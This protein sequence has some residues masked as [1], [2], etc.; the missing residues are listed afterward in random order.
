MNTPLLIPHAQPC[1]ELS[2]AQALSPVGAGK[3]ISQQSSCP[4]YLLLVERMKK[5]RLVTFSSSL[6][7]LFVFGHWKLSSLCKDRAAHLL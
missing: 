3:P 2:S 7:P 6:L 1:D 4:P 5:G